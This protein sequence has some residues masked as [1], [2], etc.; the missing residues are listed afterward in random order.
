MRVIRRIAQFELATILY[1]PIALLLMAVF[2][3]DAGILFVQIVSDLSMAA[4]S[5]GSGVESL[6]E[7]LFSGR[8]GMFVPLTG[9]LYLYIPLITMG[10]ISR[11]LQSGSFL[12]LQSS[13]VRAREIVFGK[14]LA[15][16]VYIVAMMVMLVVF[17]LIA[18]G[19]VE[20][21]DYLAVLSGILGLFLLACT[22]GAIGLFMSSLTSY[23]AVAAI[24][25]LATL[26]LLS[27]SNSLGQTIPIVG[28]ITYWLHMGG[29]AYDFI[30]GLVETKNVFYFLA[31]IGMFLGFTTLKLSAGRKVEGAAVRAAKY[32]AV[33]LVAIAAI[34]IAAQ[35]AISTYYDMTRGKYQSLSKESDDVASQIPGEWKI[36]TFAN[37][38]DRRFFSY[39]P[40]FRRLSYFFMD[41][42]RRVH[43]DISFEQVYYYRAVDDSVLYRLHPGKTDREIAEVIAGRY[44]LDFER[45]L[46]PVEIQRI[47]D[48]RAEG[49]ITHL[50]QWGDKT[51]RMRDYLGLI[52]EPR[53]QEITA[54]LKRL[55]IGP[56]TITYSAGHGERDVHGKGGSNYYWA[57]TNPNNRRALMSQ[58]FD[59]A[60]T[61]WAAP[62]PQTTDILLIA[63]PKVAFGSDEVAHIHDFIARG[64]NMVIAVEPGGQGS[65]N[66]IIS[67]LGVALSNTPVLS[68]DEEYGETSFPTR[69]SESVPESF[70][71]P[72]RS[73]SKFVLL[74]RP[75]SLEVLPDSVFSGTPILISGG[76]NEIRTLGVG[77]TREVNGSEQRIFVIGDADFMG[78]GAMGRFDTFNTAF[79]TQLFAWLSNEEFPPPIKF[80][81]HQDTELKIGKN[82]VML[83]RITILGI[84]PL[85]F[86]SIA[87]TIHYRRRRR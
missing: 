61:D 44:G 30:F 81:D 28:R 19:I 18:G 26:S 50:L 48:L 24:A 23:P 73:G 71:Y 80:D 10:L 16:I 31:I 29:R 69:Y 57:L 34:Q 1:S 25:T 41:S 60:P 74:D 43:S 64:G 27:V 13:P 79:V 87:A 42:Y 21:L 52:Q 86:F 56:S 85:F 33:F 78:N 70:S 65:I 51:V 8:T 58:G 17:M 46:S 3:F 54:A 20:N 59:F 2:V 82:G 49:G 75:L 32:A 77:L 7:R 11:E 84:F 62:I 36:T 45:V 72:P 5:S 38:L 68:D 22:Y 76:E 47:I 67:T 83:L 35:P 40:W 14:Y 4:V 55:L 9:R 12:L 66:D 15:L 39:A 6:T 37:V 53:E 63:D